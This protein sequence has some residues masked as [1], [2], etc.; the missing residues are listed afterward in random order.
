MTEKRLTDKEAREILKAAEQRISDEE[1]RAIFEAQLDQDEIELP[2]V[3]KKLDNVPQ[4]G[5]ETKL[6]LKAPLPLFGNEP[7]TKP[8]NQAKEEV[9]TVPEPEAEAPTVPEPAAKDTP[10]KDPEQDLEALYE[11]AHKRATELYEGL[12]EDFKSIKTETET[13]IDSFKVDI[14]SSENLISTSKP[15]FPELVT[16][17]ENA[18]KT[19]EGINSKISDIESSLDKASKLLA[20]KDGKS[21]TL[22]KM[23]EEIDK[24]YKSKDELSALRAEINPGKGTALDNLYAACDQQMRA[25]G[26]AAKAAPGEQEMPTVP[27]PLAKGPAVPEPAAEA[28]TVPEPVTEA[29]TVPEPVAERPAVPEP[30]AERPTVPEPEV[31]APATPEPEKPEAKGEKFEWDKAQLGGNLTALKYGSKFEDQVTFLQENLHDIGAYQ[32]TRTKEDNADGIFG[33]DTKAAATRAQ[34]A[35]RSAGAGTAVDGKAYVQTWAALA[36]LKE[37]GT[38]LTADGKIPEDAKEEVLKSYKENLTQGGKIVLGTQ[39]L[40]SD[41]IVQNGIDPKS[42]VAAAEAGLESSK[43]AA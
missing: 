39:Q 40:E 27:E 4:P 20:K 30:V 5:E 1:A 15:P 25:N 43:G 28:S 35:F 37:T 24:A 31:K 19:L 36:A 41:S 16:A 14:K 22:V 21:E 18:K 34:Q 10:K 2:S 3:P 6:P 38:K 11:T 12:A 32:N 23:S 33:G 8:G 26:L 7:V 9:P 17:S 42:I 29:P 13:E